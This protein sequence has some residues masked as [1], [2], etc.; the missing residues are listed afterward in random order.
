[1]IRRLD[2]ETF[3]RTFQINRNNTITPYAERFTGVP[4]QSSPGGILRP[5]EPAEPTQVEGALKGKDP[6]A[7]ADGYSVVHIS[8]FSSAVQQCITEHGQTHP[9]CSGRLVTAYNL[10]TKWGVSAIVRL[11]C[12]SC[13]FVSQK[14]QTVPR[15]HNAHS[16]SKSSGAQPKPCRWFKLY[17][18]W[19]C[20]CAAFVCRNGNQH[21]DTII[22]AKTTKH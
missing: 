20:R 10:I 2:K 21:S 9:A 3:N 12:D 18:H 19:Q 7:V 1:M 6:D 4:H 8:T 13:D 16:R 17:Q 22:I 11:K 5:T 14:K 15:N